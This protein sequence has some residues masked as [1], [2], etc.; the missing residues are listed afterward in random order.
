MIASFFRTPAILSLV[1]AV[2]VSAI[3]WIVFIQGGDSLPLNGRLYALAGIV[4][5]LGF[6][7][8]TTARDV[9]FARVP[10]G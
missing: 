4:S 9:R 10:R 5:L 6:G 1:G 3:L 7:I 2:A 8:W